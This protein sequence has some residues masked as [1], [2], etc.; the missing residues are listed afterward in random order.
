MADTGADNQSRESRITRE[1]LAFYRQTLEW[2]A[3]HHAHAASETKH[4][5]AAEERDNAVWK[6]SGQAIAYAFALVELL[7]RGYTG[8]TWALMRAVHE[9][10]RLIIAATAE[11]EERIVRRWLR[12]QEV[13]QRDA[14]EAEQRQATR[15][16]EQ[17]TAA[18][19]EPLD[20]DVGALSRT[21]YRGMSAAAHHQRSIVDEGVD[22]ESRTMIYGPDPRQSERLAYAA[23]AGA[24]IHEVL[25]ITAARCCTST[26]RRFGSTWSQ[27]TA[28]SRRSLKRWTRTTC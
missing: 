25:L 19:L 12:N 3:H 28:G 8:Q 1:T 14:R 26:V 2:L 24:L 7:D 4:D 15:V 5:L 22:H 17:M 27:C 9:V 18:G 21:I 11:G 23:F 13:A 10:D 20:A 16:S 6:L